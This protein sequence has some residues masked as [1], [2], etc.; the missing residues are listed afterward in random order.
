MHD[1][2]LYWNY[3]PTAPDFQQN[4]FQKQ[5]KKLWLNGLALAFQ[6]PRPSQSRHEA[7]VMAQPG[8]ACL[9]PAWFGSQPQAGPGTAL[10][11]R[12]LAQI[13]LPLQ[14]VH[15]YP[16]AFPIDPMLTPSTRTDHSTTV[17][18]S[19]TTVNGH[20][21]AQWK[22]RGAAASDAS[23]VGVTQHWRTTLTRK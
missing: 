6:V 16:I 7:V 10:A 4:D 12:A 15:V 2:L 5:P 13:A 21:R 20:S 14:P 17:P 3:F 9:G 11:E 1:L 22:W 23:D 18:G 19:S 8:L